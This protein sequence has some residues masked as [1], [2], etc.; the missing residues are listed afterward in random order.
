VKFLDYF[1]F[2]PQCFDL[3][4]K[5]WFSKSDPIVILYEKKALSDEWTFIGRTEPLKNDLNP[6]FSRKITLVS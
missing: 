4:D 1:D 5:D 2:C 6:S 3:V